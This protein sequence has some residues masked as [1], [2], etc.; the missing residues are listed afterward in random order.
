MPLSQLLRS[1]DRELKV[2]LQ[3]ILFDRSLSPVMCYWGDINQ[4]ILNLLV[5]AAIGVS[6][7]EP[8]SP[9]RMSAGVQVRVCPRVI[10]RLPTNMEAG[11]DLRRRWAG[12]RL[13][14]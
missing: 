1:S 14:S 7:F 8:F 9:P 5:N 6:I 2:E 12:V 11:S 13:F 3:L 10:A 4:V